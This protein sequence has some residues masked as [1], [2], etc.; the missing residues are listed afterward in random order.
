MPAQLESWKLP[1]IFCHRGSGQSAPENTLAGIQWSRNLG[2]F[3]IH[4]DV[5]FTADG[6]PILMSDPTLDRTAQTHGI[7]S[8]TFFD[9]M[10]TLDVGIWFGNE[11]SG[12]RIPTLFQALK[13]CQELNIYP[14]FELQ[15]EIGQ[16]I[17][18][19]E[20]VIEIFKNSW[21]TEEHYPI[22]ATS[23]FDCLETLMQS[24]H[25][26]PRA[27]V[28][29]SELNEKNIKNQNLTCSSVLI[30]E[31]L[32]NPDVI[33]RIHSNMLHVIALRVND[34]ERALDLVYQGADAIITDNLDGIGPNFF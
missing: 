17:A 27:I 30:N 25:D 31:K 9:Q 1:R 13:A 33:A 16:E 15:P 14:I 20:T 18:L 28:W 6:V 26:I 11:F 4:L 5:R 3:G 23:N 24:S 32:I 22:V 2:F 19:A 10:N 7:V 29:N 8:E 34:S 21:N 12:E